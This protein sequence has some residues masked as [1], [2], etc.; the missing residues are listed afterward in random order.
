MG[1]AYPSPGFGG[2]ICLCRSTLLVE[3]EAA[4]RHIETCIGR[5]QAVRILA[6]RRHLLLAIIHTM[7]GILQLTQALSLVR[8]EIS[9]L[10][11]FKTRQQKRQKRETQ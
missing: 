9:G 1:D 3:I 5:A 11:D 2:S 4:G 7:I 10:R 8:I 6:C